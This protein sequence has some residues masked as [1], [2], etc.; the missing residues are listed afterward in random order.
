MVKKSHDFFEHNYF[1][2]LFA[3]KSNLFGKRK[4]ANQASVVGVEVGKGGLC[5]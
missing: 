1:P 4:K 3:K 5:I 2:V